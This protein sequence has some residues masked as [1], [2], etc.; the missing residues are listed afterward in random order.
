MVW[1]G[2]TAH[3]LRMCK[4]SASLTTQGSIMLTAIHELTNDSISAEANTSSHNHVPATSRV[5]WNPE[6]HYR[7]LKGPPTTLHYPQPHDWS[8]KQLRLPACFK[9]LT[10]LL[11]RSGF[12]EIIFQIK[13]QSPP[14]SVIFSSFSGEFHAEYLKQWAKFPLLQIDRGTNTAYRRAVPR[15]C[16]CKYVGQNVK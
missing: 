1:T 7:M 15:V 16:Y 9:R 4:F 10:N 13:A 8:C 6:D 5:L 3:L 11:Q 12:S 14:S 2:T